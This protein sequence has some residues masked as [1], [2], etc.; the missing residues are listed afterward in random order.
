MAEIATS[1]EFFS[2]LRCL[3]DAWCG[4]RCLKALSRILPAFL[5]FNGLTDG[6]RDLY[7][8]LRNVRAFAKD[9]LTESEMETVSS[10][11]AA[12]SRVIYGSAEELRF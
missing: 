7:D 5:G 10:L 11:I 2:T 1:A 9:E 4:R 6:W 8:A 12:A 3:I